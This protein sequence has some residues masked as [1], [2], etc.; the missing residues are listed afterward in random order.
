MIPRAAL[1]NF[2]LLVASAIVNSLDFNVLD[3]LNLNSNVAGV[4]GASGCRIKDGF[5]FKKATKSLVTSEDVTSELISSL[6]QHKEWIIEFKLNP[7][8]FHK[9]TILWLQQRSTGTPLLG[10]WVRVGRNAK[11]GIQYFGK[12]KVEYLTLHDKGKSYEDSGWKSVIFHYNKRKN[13]GYVIDMYVDCVKTDSKKATF[14]LRNA[15]KEDIELRVAQ[16]EVAGKIFSRWKGG[17]ADFR[18][19][20]NRNISAYVHPSR[21][22]TPPRAHSPPMMAADTPG[23]SAVDLGSVAANEMARVIGGQT[24]LMT[25]DISQILTRL[26]SIS[27]IATSDHLMREILN[28]VKGMKTQQASQIL[29]I[30]T[31]RELIHIIGTE[32]HNEIEERKAENVFSAND[33]VLVGNACDMKPC[34]PFVPCTP[35]KDGGYKC[36]RCPLGLEGDGRNCTDENEC[37]EN[38]C[39]PTTTCTNKLPGFHCSECPRGFRGEEMVGIGREMAKIRKQKCKDID[40]C[41][42]GTHLCDPN[43]ICMNIDGSYKCGDCKSGFK[44]DQK[45]KCLFAAPCEGKRG[46]STNPCSIYATCEKDVDKPRCKCRPAFSGDGFVC[47]KDTDG[48]GVPD[49]PLGCVGSQCKGDNCP[50]IPNSGQEDMDG[51]GK[52][53]VCDADIDGDT[54]WN[55]QDNCPFHPNKEQRN[56]DSDDWGDNCDNCPFVYNPDQLDSDGDGKGDVCDD[57]Y[58]DDGIDNVVDNCQHTYNPTQEDR[59]VDGVGDLCDNCPDHS[60][61][62]QNDKNQNGVG[63]ACDNNIDSDSDGVIDIFDNCPHIANADQLDT[64]NDGKGDVC[65]G[66]MDDDGVV[67]ELDNCPL[68][69]NDQQVDSDDNRIGNECEGDADGDKIPNTKDFCPNNKHISKTDF[70]KHDVI[71]LGVMDR[72]AQRAPNWQ[73]SDEGKE[74]VQ[75]ANSAPS[76][77]LGKPSY[78]GFDMTMNLYVNTKSDDDFIGVAFGFQNVRNFYLL[79]WKQKAQS[80]WRSSPSFL[81]RAT[82]GLELKVIRSETGPSALLRQAL[83]HSGNFTGQQ[84]ILWKDK[85]LRGWEDKTPYSFKLMHRPSVGLIRLIVH[86]SSAL[87]LDTGYIFDQHLRGGKIGPYAFSQAAVVWSG[88]KIKCND[89][90]PLEVKRALQGHNSWP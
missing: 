16:R 9:G 64:D 69:R 55:N 56:S 46:T 41:S 43:A 31:L 59:D 66:D 25:P 32:Q 10:L 37:Q 47:N 11:Y 83:W 3:A 20:F 44:R 71:L 33:T 26:S 21:C 4:Q 75:V 90:L 30:K 38:P 28:I 51:D 84:T 50:F 57:D 58:D 34:Y 22:W 14:S 36:G 87:F 70:R 67:N 61:S 24:N 18:F 79:S 74:V 5:F 48:D 85:E 78:A 65:D 73:I 12:K 63:D 82:S 86:R 52:G 40:E 23:S 77:I 49:E 76:I 62:D 35:L 8:P 27:P 45:G 13:K 80:Y 1:V 89:E 68:I 39:A 53:D 54:M 6:K 15:P 88:I 60:N 72:D 42:E 81:S 29:E 19:I 2:L 17:L 7:Q